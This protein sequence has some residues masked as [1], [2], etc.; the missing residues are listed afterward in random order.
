MDQP[1][2]SCQVVLVEQAEELEM[3]RGHWVSLALRV[4][5]G[6]DAIQIWMAPSLSPRTVQ[7]PSSKLALV[8]SWLKSS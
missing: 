3:E 6:E 2:E 1:V 8:T 7:S 5:G 4:L